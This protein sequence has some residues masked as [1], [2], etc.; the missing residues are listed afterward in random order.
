MNTIELKKFLDDCNDRKIEM[1]V[2][3]IDKLPKRIK[4]KKEYGIVINLSVSSES[5][6]HWTGLYIDSKK[7]AFYM[8]SLGFKYKSNFIDKFINKNC[9]TYT[10]NKTQLQQLNSKVCGMYSTCFILHMMSGGTLE[11][12]I[13]KFSKN[14]YLNDAFIIKNYNYYLRNRR[15][16]KLLL[17]LRN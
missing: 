13:Q 4:K 16:R 1:I 11:L 9:K 8:D 7:N 12:F 6:S 17:K 10:Y 15:I 5:G 2:C 3:A 14:L